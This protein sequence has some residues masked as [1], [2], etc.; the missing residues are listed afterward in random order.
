M[1]KSEQVLS[2]IQRAVFLP[3]C[4]ETCHWILVSLIIMV[5]QARPDILLRMIAI[6]IQ[7]QFA[8]SDLLSAFESL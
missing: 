4:S 7:T 6:E 2:L 3:G 5:L 8:Q 1:G